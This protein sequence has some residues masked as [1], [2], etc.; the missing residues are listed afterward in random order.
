MTQKDLN[1]LQQTLVSKFQVYNIGHEC[2]KRRKV[3]VVDAL[4]SLREDSLGW[5]N[6]LVAEQSKG[7]V[8][9]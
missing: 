6:H 7:K 8:V 5:E 2:E 1:D 3:V 4:L 9:H